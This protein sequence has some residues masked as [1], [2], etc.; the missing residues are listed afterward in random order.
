MPCPKNIDQYDVSSD[1]TST[2]DALA[3]GGVDKESYGYLYPPETC[4]SDLIQ[5]ALCEANAPRTDK[6]V[7]FLADEA[8]RS[9][10]MLYDD[11]LSSCYLQSKVK[12]S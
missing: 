7:Q 11:P 12:T 3:D 4:S 10:P 1:N 8:F 6:W 9:T 2:I 5:G